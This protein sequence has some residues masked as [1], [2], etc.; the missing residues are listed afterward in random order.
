M[1]L[2]NL[3]RVQL[4][5]GL[6]LGLGLLVFAPRM[7]ALFE[8]P[9][10]DVALVLRAMV[11][12]LLLEGLASVPLTWYEAELKIGRSLLPELART[13]TYCAA[14]LV[15]AL[16]GCGVWSFIAAMIVS[17]A[18]YTLLLWARARSSA[19]HAPMPLHYEP[20][21]TR[22]SSSRARSPSAASGSSP[23]PSPT[24]TR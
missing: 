5:W 3:L 4:G 12:Y 8:S 22:A 2:G 16:A 1:P 21:Q 20:E 13:F 24:P 11:V 6:A 10:P 14:A 9:R 19:H 15:L 18:I 23:S 7:A 17:Q